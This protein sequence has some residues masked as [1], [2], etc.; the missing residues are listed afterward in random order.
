MNMSGGGFELPADKMH[1]HLYAKIVNYFNKT[2][3]NRIA[4]F[5]L[6]YNLTPHATYPTQLRQSVE[7][8]RHVLTTQPGR[9]P[10]SIFL[11]G[12][13]AGANLALAVLLHLSR[14]HPEIDPLPLQQPLGGV[15]TLGAWTSFR[16]DFPS[17]ET[18]RYKDL[19]GRQHGAR[20]SAAYLNGKPGDAWNQPLLAPTE[21]WDGSKV[22]DVL[23]L[24][25]GDEVLLDAVEEMY[26]KFKVRILS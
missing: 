20:W 24:V 23:F 3:D 22:K 11:G 14:P 25:G 9:S 8:L 26:A 21:W 10:S 12:D 17:V 1:F 18:N 5:F 7:A 4:F 6:G 16:L 2:Q 13:S 15:F 19:A